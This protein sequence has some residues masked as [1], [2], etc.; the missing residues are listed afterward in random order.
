[1]NEY[2]A[3]LGPHST[4]SSLLEASLSVVSWAGYIRDIGAALTGSHPCKLPSAVYTKGKPQDIIQS[5]TVGDSL[6]L[7]LSSDAT[8]QDLDDS[9]PDICRR[10]VANA[11][12]VWRQIIRV[13]EL[14]LDS[15]VSVSEVVSTIAAVVKEFNQTFHPFMNRCKKPSSSSTGSKPLLGL[16]ASDIKIIY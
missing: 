5:D 11:F 16:I 12:H 2:C 13:K 15:S 10:A 8:Y 3:I 1:M 7:G 6:T 4:Y 9:I 14:A